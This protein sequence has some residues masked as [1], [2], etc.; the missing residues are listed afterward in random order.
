RSLAGRSRVPVASLALHWLKRQGVAP[1]FGASRPEQV[2]EIV[3]AWAHAPPDDAL[4][5]A[6]RIGRGALDA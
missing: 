6:D 4:A 2:D 1:V 3:E 5:E